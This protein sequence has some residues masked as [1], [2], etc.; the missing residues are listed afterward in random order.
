MVQSNDTVLTL[1]APAEQG[2]PAG[3]VAVV[4]SA[5][6]DAHASLSPTD[7]LADGIACDIAFEGCLADVAEAVVRQVLADQPVDVF[8]QPNTGDRR[9]MLMVA[10]MDSTMVTSETLDD[11][12]AHAGLKDRIAAITERAMRGELDFESALR[13]RVGM[14]KGLA[15][16]ALDETFA[17]IVYMPGAKALVQTMRANGA[18]CLLVSGGFTAFTGRVAAWLGFHDHRANTLHVE[19]GVLV[20]TVGEP[21]LGREAKVKTLVEEAG[22]LRLPL[23]RTLAVGD[24][25]NDLAMLQAAGLGV[26]YHAKPL[27]REAARFRV[28]HGDQT[29]L[30]FAQ[31]YRQAEF[32]AG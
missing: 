2:L 4:R 24:G 12:A 25:A 1:V 3:T 29:A 6:K 8:V 19:N 17:D 32:I 14:L 13:E 27:V 11:L 18:T 20:G 23:T 10:D 28:D 31:G 16:S 26:A 7:W 21:I 30:L 22:K 15:A 9:K 5:L